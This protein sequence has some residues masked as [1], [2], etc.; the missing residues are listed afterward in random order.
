MMAATTPLRAPCKLLCLAM[1]GIFLV[2][3]AAAETPAIDN[4]RKAC[5]DTLPLDGCL[6]ATQTLIDGA[7][8]EADRV[9]A[10]RARGLRYHSEF[11]ANGSYAAEAIADYSAVLAIEPWPPT[12]FNRAHVLRNLG[13]EDEALADLKRAVELRP[14]YGLAWLDISLIYGNRSMHAEAIDAANRAIA[15]AD[16]PD[17]QKSMA[18]N[19]VGYSNLKLKV[20]TVAEEAFKKAIEHNP[21]NAG[22]H[23]NLTRTYIYMNDKKRAKEF[24]DKAIAL[25]P[26]DTWNS[27]LAEAIGTVD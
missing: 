5:E 1:I 14:G 27:V 25:D 11:L 8:E 18:W 4:V 19:N 17:E 20:L 22:A 15:D 21:Q 26:S 24:L 2:A 6:K 23:R 12:Y 10:F 16:L 13:K 9:A 3:P 7:P